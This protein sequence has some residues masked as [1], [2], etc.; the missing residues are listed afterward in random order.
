MELDWIA[1]DP[2]TGRLSS[3]KR[4]T[5][6]GEFVAHVEDLRELDESYTE[7]G[8]ADR[9][10]PY[11]AF[12]FRGG[13]AVVH[14]FAAEDRVLLMSGD[15]VVADGECVLIPVLGN[16]G[17]VWTGEFVLGADRAWAVVWQF[18]RHGLVDDL[19]RWEEL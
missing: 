4:R 1:T 15:G 19:G 3:S 16:E 17:S 14:Q 13:Y 10:Y 6:V 9:A 5:T 12:A 18:L 11:L 2:E 7:V 8:L